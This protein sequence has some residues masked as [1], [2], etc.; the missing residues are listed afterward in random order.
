MTVDLDYLKHKTTNPEDP[1][2]D[3][4][5][6]PITES[7]CR[8][9]NGVKLTYEEKALL[10][11]DELEWYQWCIGWIGLKLPGMTLSPILRRLVELRKERG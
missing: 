9:P 1:D 3:Y 2:A 4:D 11:P 8:E 6:E 7:M 10:L 5:F